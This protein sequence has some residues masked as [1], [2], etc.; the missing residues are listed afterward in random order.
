ML[1]GGAKFV[2]TQVEPEKA[3]MLES[4]RFAVEEVARAFRVPQHMLQ[5]AAPGVQSYASNEEN[6]IQFAVYT[7][8]PYLAKLEAAYSS[9]L[10][11]EAFIKFN[12]DGLLRGDLGESLRRLLDCASVRLYEHQRRASS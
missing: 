12:M 3:Q 8:R 1:G 4:R 7:L 6:A 11:G 9:L 5:V 10:P 2:S